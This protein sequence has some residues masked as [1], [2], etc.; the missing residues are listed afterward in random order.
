MQY[1]AREDIEK[2]IADTKQPPSRFEAIE[3]T[4]GPYECNVCL[5]YRHELTLFHTD[6]M[7]AFC[8]YCVTETIAKLRPTCPLCKQCIFEHAT[9]RLKFIKPTPND[10][11]WIDRIQFRCKDCNFTGDLFKAR[12]HAKECE[13]LFAHQP[14][15]H[16]PKWESVNSQRR[17]VV[18]NCKT[19]DF[20]NRRDRLLLHYFNGL[21]IAARMTKW[22]KTIRQLRTD[23]AKL[24]EKDPDKIKIYK[25]THVELVDTEIVGD[26]ARTNGATYICSFDDLPQLSKHCLCL[27]LEHIGPAPL[28][29]AEPDQSLGPSASWGT[30]TNTPVSNISR[31][32]PAGMESSDEEEDG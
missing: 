8:A 4:V 16:I 29:S 26:V 18:S 5:L 27:T 30:S 23:I 24:A 13:K 31:G 28:L 11:Y 9:S 32:I 21:Q 14:P 15:K 12:D 2:L 7:K 6:C 19:N 10:H 1:V 22:S 25:F 20:P 17:E 3:A